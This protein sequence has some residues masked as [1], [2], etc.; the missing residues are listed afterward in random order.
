MANEND[1]L[2][3]PKTVLQVM[4]QF[5]TVMCADPDIPPDAISRLENLLRKGT[6][7]KPEE[8]NSA[9]FERSS[10]GEK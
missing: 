1:H 3:I 6:V 10:D 8:I 9:I 7:P 2:V 4:E 5:I